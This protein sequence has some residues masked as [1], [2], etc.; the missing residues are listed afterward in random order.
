M[1]AG[2]AAALRG[3]LTSAL[4]PQHDPISDSI[5]TLLQSYQIS[6]NPARI[7][8][9][10]ADWTLLVTSGPHGDKLA[11]GFRGCHAALS[12]ATL[13][14]VDLDPQLDLLVVA[15]LS[16][17]Q[18]LSL[19]TRAAPRTLR[20]LA[21]SIRTLR[22]LVPPLSDLAPHLDLLSCN[23]AEW[24]AIPPDTQARLRALIPLIAVT[25][26]PR[27]ARLLLGDQQLEI[28]AFPRTHPPR[29]TN[30]AGEAFASTLI[31]RL[32]L[33]GW[34][35]GQPLRPGPLRSAAQAATAAAAL[36]LDLDR[37][38]F[39]TP[40]DIDSALDRGFIAEPAHPTDQPSA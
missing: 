22:D 37:F 8:D 28:P 16:T 26:G 19:L 6:H 1:G 25:L 40:A 3:T 2:F 27:G 15:G 10:A 31:A 11:V 36:V 30:R 24:T 7:P 4:G 23:H 12:P 13:A 32:W 34:R 9:R 33:S 29:D 17:A 20:L 5:S 14:Q 39:P 35:R 18:S 38:G 21:P